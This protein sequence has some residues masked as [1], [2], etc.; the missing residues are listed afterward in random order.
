MRP[1]SAVARTKSHLAN[2][3]V[4]QR[5]HHFPKNSPGIL[6]QPKSSL[7][8]SLAKVPNSTPQSV[9]RSPSSKTGKSSESGEWRHPVL[10]SLATSPMCRPQ[11]AE[12][13]RVTTPRIS[14][15][16]ETKN[17]TD[18]F[19][20]KDSKVSMVNIV[21]KI[22]TSSKKKRDHSRSPRKH[23][24][25]AFMQQRSFSWSSPPSETSR[26]KQASRKSTFAQERLFGQK[27]VDLRRN[28]IRK[29]LEIKVYTTSGCTVNL[30]YVIIVV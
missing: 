3:L 9:V 26:K 5:G 1:R 22:N 10:S 24:R 6:S 21:T 19:D 25:K 12:S 28:L 11:S 8:P 4:S 13:P 7:T 29:M 27:F 14:I 16:K 2:N 15:N 30:V 18:T 20:K 23:S 17:T